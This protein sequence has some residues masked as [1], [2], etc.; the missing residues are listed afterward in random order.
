MA[1]NV[2]IRRNLTCRATPVILAVLLLLLG[3]L[4]PVAYAWNESGHRV[5][6]ATAA[7]HM[8]AKLRSRVVAALKAHPRYKEDFAAYR[9]RR[10]RGLTEAQWLMGQ[11]AAW[12][13]HARSFDNAPRRSRDALV[14]RYHRGNWHYINLPL[15]LTEADGAL[16]IKD[17]ARSPSNSK[18]KRK[19]KRPRDVLTAL[20]FIEAKLNDPKTPLSEQGLWISWALHLIADVHQPLHTTAMFSKNRWPRGDRGGNE[21]KIAGSGRADR[22]DSLHYYWDRAI[23]NRRKPQEIRALVNVLNKQKTSG[24]AE[25]ETEPLKWIREGHVIAERLVYRPLRPQIVASPVVKIPKEYSQKTHAAALKLGAVAA[26]RT[27]LW[28]AAALKEY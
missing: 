20:S 28:L 3:A 12:P 26:H 13:D 21:I 15:Y 22:L 2:Q 23:S 6:A 16:R 14:K 5:I 19:L 18:R 24:F 9:P 27:S 11:A 7:E 8:S 17:P 1:R 10:L 25:N 4:S